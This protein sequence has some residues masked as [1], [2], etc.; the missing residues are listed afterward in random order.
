VQKFNLSCKTLH[1][2][3]TLFNQSEPFLYQTK[4]AY[5]IHSFFYNSPIRALLLSNRPIRAL[6]ILAVYISHPTIH[7]SQLFAFTNQSLYYIQN[8]CHQ[9]KLFFP[10]SQLF[11]NL[12][13]N[14]PITAYV[15]FESTNQSPCDIPL[16]VGASHCVCVLGGHFVSF[17]ETQKGY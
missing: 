15:T 10:N 5:T 16:C 14:R 17:R 12:F 4:L 6:V 3:V 13:Y 8:P 2:C 1:K 9:I 7:Y 11:G